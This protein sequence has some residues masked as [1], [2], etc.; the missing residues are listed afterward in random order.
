MSR[1]IF[2]AGQVTITEE[3]SGIGAGHFNVQV[4]RRSVAVPFNVENRER[5]L[6]FLPHV[7]HGLTLPRPGEGK[8][9][10]GWRDKMHHV[11]KE[12]EAAI[13]ARKPKPRKPRKASNGR[14]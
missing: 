6:D 4:G 7:A 14:V 13:E 2:S 5:V 10:E 1:K 8:L 9:G 3:P 12:H 11:A